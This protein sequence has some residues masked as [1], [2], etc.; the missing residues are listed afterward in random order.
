MPESSTSRGDYNIGVASYSDANALVQSIQFQGETDEYEAKDGNGITAA[1]VVTNERK[2]VTIEL[3]IK[4]AYTPPA[5]GSSLTIGSVA[6]K[7]L[8]STVTESNT[9]FKKATVNAV[10]FIDGNLP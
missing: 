3:I 2:R 9:D 6:Y 4:A 5:I 10:R 8:N 7:V 1:H